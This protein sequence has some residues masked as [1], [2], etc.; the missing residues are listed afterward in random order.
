MKGIAIQL[1]DTSPGARAQAYQYQASA[2]RYDTGS[3]LLGVIGLITLLGATTFGITAHDLSRVPSPG[4]TPQPQP[5]HGG[6]VI[7]FKRPDNDTPNPA[8]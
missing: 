4:P 2:Q 1:N 7:P 5:T 6:R 8:V 3:D